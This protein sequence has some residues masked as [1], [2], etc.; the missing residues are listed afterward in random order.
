MEHHH[1]PYSPELREIVERNR[2]WNVEIQG[3]RI[4]LRRPA[5]ERTVFQQK[6][7]GC[8]TTFSRRARSRQLRKIAE[9][10]WLAAGPGLF[11]T[12][13]YPDECADHDM[14]ERA[15]HRYQIHRWIEG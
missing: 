12:L 10:D 6:T 3:K 11:L 4:T 1:C 2:P 7:R 15:T 5:P 14:K 8:I 13:T 9:I